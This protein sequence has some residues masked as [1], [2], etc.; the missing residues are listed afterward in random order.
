MALTFGECLLREVRI[1]AG[2][3]QDQLSDGLLEICGLSVS[4]TLLSFYE[5]NKRP[6]PT[7]TMRGICIVLGCSEKDIYEWPM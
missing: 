6:I 2:F 1:R 4:T 5:N 3:T 7:V